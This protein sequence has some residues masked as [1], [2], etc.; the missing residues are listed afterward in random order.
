MNEWI[1]KAFDILKIFGDFNADKEENGIQSRRSGGRGGG[2]A[3]HKVVGGT[4]SKIIK[5][6]NFQWLKTSSKKSVKK[7]VKNIC[8][9]KGTPKNQH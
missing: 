4:K 6:L 1:C 5:Y 2:K 7:F 3:P 8:Q 9:K